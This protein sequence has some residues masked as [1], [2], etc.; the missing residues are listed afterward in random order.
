MSNYNRLIKTLINIWLNY[1]RIPENKK[2]DLKRARGVLMNMVM[3]I[4]HFRKTFMG[5][6]LCENS[7]LGVCDIS[8]F[9]PQYE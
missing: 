1:H 6:L 9:E 3:L 2:M 7:V 5:Y 4:Y 8:S